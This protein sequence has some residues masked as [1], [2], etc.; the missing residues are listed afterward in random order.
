MNLG[1]TLLACATCYGAAGS[2]QAQGFNAGILVL[3]ALVA[4]VLSGVGCFMFTLARRARRA[5][6]ATPAPGRASA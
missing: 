5:A 2:P 4:L 6:A 3:L 1:S